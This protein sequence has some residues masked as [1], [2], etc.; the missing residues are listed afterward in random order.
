[1]VNFHPSLCPLRAWLLFK[2]ALNG[3]YLFSK[4]NLLSIQAYN[5]YPIITLLVKD[6]DKPKPT[7]LFVLNGVSMPE[8]QWA[9]RSKRSSSDQSAK[10]PRLAMTLFISAQGPFEFFKERVAL[11]PV[12]AEAFVEQAAKSVEEFLPDRLP[13]L[14]NNVGDELV[15]LHHFLLRQE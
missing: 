3:S 6:K 4:W 1:M 2:Y 15:Q 7:C 10:P 11:L 14:E 8:A 5:F 9:M 13:P 12:R